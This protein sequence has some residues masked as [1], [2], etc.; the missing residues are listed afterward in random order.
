MGD[1]GSARRPLC[2]EPLRAFLLLLLAI[3][4]PTF[5]LLPTDNS[6]TTPAALVA[7]APAIAAAARSPRAT[8]RRLV[9]SGRDCRVLSLTRPAAVRRKHLDHRDPFQ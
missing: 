5:H 6:P 9:P 7:A 4:P 2:A 3:S 8:F 1:F